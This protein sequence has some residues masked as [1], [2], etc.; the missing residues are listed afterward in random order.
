[1]SNDTTDSGGPQRGFGRR[2]SGPPRGA[3]PKPAPKPVRRRGKRLNAVIALVFVGLLAAIGGTAA[4]L[5]YDLPKL[6]DDQHLWSVARE[7]G[8]TFEDVN[9][10]VL[11]TR[12]ARNG[13]KVSISQLPI[14]VPR[15]FLAAED[16]R[17]YQHGPVEVR[18]I[19]R[20]AFSNVRSDG[21]DQGASTLTQ[22]IAKTLFLKPDRTLKR[23]IQEAFIAWRLEG[24]LT[25]DEV[26]ELYL[27]R[28]YFGERSYGLDAASVQ[29]FGHS[30]QTL[31][32][33]EAAL[34]A[35]L[36]KAPSRLSP[37]RN[38]P[39]AVKRSQ[40]VLTV[41][42]EER[43][44]TPAQEA[45]AIE[46]PP[47][48]SPPPSGDR[49][50]GYVLDLA[51]AEATAIAGENAPDLVVRLTID[52]VLQLKAQTIV[53]EAIARDG[54]SVNASQ[55]AM[56]AMTPDGAIRAV[57]GGVDHD[58]SPFNWATQ[59]RRQPGSAFKPLV[60]A[61]ALETGVRPEDLKTD[62]P[63]NI[64]GWRPSNYG[65]GYSGVMR[66]DQAL[67]RSVNTI[68]A[69]LAQQVGRDKLGEISRRFGLSGIPAQPNLTVALGSYEVTLRELTNAFQVFQ[70]GGER[71]ASY[72]I[73]SITTSSGETIWQHTPTAAAPVYDQRLAGQMVRMMEGVV[74][75][76][77]GHRADFGRP[78]AGKTG[79]SQDWRDAWFVGFTPDWAAGVWVGNDDGDLMAGVTGGTLPADIWRRFMI[80]AHKG[81]AVHDFDF[82]QAA[83]ALPVAAEPMEET[84]AHDEQK[85]LTEEDTPSPEARA[86]FYDS[87]ADDF[88]REGR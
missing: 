55:A 34:L 72:L 44:I 50:F 76:G 37:T 88:A 68:A 22:Q 33:G 56:I 86:A 49:D 6:P 4:W 41:M 24:R 23:K 54:R 40:T 47:T 85:P 70:N 84:D 67:A 20:A 74:Y 82:I 15:A 79:T 75:G 39:D 62:K 43:W 36:P 35:S 31:T 77:T 71:R 83:E 25:K 51:A 11:A 53:A 80:E 64:G 13:H 59:A 2:A 28:I 66:V 52:P 5:F 61:A 58:E 27:N 73:T 87:L 21:P 78:A 57:V 38:M 46:A 12:C 8:I 26:L 16:R 29:Y 30:A 42:R 69:Q 10:Q 48:L 65:G 14:Y 7:P 17:F 9:G 60:Y 18:S 1:M 32:V 19:V 45:A 3:S 63:V 81:V